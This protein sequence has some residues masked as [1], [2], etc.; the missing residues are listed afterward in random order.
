MTKKMNGLGDYDPVPE[1]PSGLNKKSDPPT[2]RKRDTV[3]NSRV[4]ALLLDP[5]PD[6]VLSL[7]LRSTLSA[8]GPDSVPGP[9]SVPGPDPDPVFSPH[10]PQLAPGPDSQTIQRVPHQMSKKARRH[11]TAACLRI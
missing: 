1:R 2:C 7:G 11:G 6:P 4:P 10:S 9:A 3:E 5:V 8:P